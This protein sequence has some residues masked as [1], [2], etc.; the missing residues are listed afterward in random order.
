MAADN[1]EAKDGRNGLLDRVALVIV[2]VAFSALAGWVLILNTEGARHGQW[3]ADHLFHHQ[4]EEITCAENRA[5]M[6]RDLERIEDEWQEIR[7]D[8]YKSRF[9]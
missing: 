8:V 6:R 4:Q 5:A 7:D 3:Q 2:G 1:E 9:D